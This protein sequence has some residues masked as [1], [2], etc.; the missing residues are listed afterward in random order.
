MDMHRASRRVGVV[1]IG[2]RPHVAP[3]AGKHAQR[4]ARAAAQ[5]GLL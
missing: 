5:R 3:V 1:E 2:S 4:G